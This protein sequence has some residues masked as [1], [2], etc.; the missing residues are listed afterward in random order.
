MT[1]T[2]TTDEPPALERPA[3]QR[4][5][6][7]L[8]TAPAVAGGGLVDLVQRR[9]RHQIT[10]SAETAYEVLLDEPLQ[11]D[12]GQPDPAQPIAVDTSAVADAVAR[13]AEGRRVPI[14]PSALHPANVAGTLRRAAGR[15]A[16]VAAFHAVRSPWYAA[17]L[18]GYAVL[19]CCG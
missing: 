13:V 15:W 6:G 17:R 5:A 2:I 3:A 14:I 19:G 12:P 18:V 10:G 9:A 11:F 16:H 8:P 4:P 1:E 7:E